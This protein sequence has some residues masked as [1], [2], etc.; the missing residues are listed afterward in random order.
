MYNM[1]YIIVVISVILFVAADVKRIEVCDVEGSTCP[2]DTHCCE[3]AVCD[4]Q[5]PETIKD[6]GNQLKT[7]C[8]DKA[9]L[10]IVPLPDYCS[11]CPICGEE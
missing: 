3:K 9:E 10:E 5:Q 6:K 1:L 8:C 7:K 4:F 2:E 11:K